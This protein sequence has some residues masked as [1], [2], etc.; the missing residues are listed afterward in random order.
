MRTILTMHPRSVKDFGSE[1]Q[2]IEN[3]RTKVTNY[4]ESDIFQGEEVFYD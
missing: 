4:F 1:H 2:G 3:G